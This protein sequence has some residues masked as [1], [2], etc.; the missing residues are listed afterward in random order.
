MLQILAEP[1]FVINKSK[2]FSRESRFNVLGAV[3]GFVTV[4]YVPCLPSKT[5]HNSLPLS[6]TDF[7]A[8][9]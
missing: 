5:A 6:H 9:L 1:A 8:Q 2:Q 4:N 3:N 7:H